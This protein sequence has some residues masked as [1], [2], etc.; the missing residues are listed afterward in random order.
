MCV[1]QRFLTFGIWCL[2][3][4]CGCRIDRV[5]LVPPSQEIEQ[6]EG[7]ASLRISSTE[8][9]A[10]SRFSFL[11]RLPDK[12]R[13]DVIDPLGRVPYQLLLMGKEAYFVVPS[14]QIYWHGEERDILEKFLGFPL[15]LP[16]LIALMSGY[17]F[18]LDQTEAVEW[19]KGWSLQKDRN[20]RIQSGRR[21]NFSFR[22]EEFFDSSSW[23]KT[24][25]YFHPLSEGRL[26]ILSFQFNQP[27][28]EETFSTSFLEGFAQKTWEEI[29]AILYETR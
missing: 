7:Y 14:K 22:V 1:F 12:G 25:V 21:E 6:I 26:K 27:Q 2:L 17:W 16:E 24:V 4:F 9:M 29:E 5:V 28:R 15:S 23:T 3:L 19:E 20:G 10:R 18:G 8:Q 13:L 11:F